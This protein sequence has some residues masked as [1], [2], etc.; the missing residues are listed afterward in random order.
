VLF[1]LRRGAGVVV[2]GFGRP[3][4]AEAAARLVAIGRRRGLVVLLGADPGL[5]A[6]VGAAG[7]HLPERALSKVRRLRQAHP[8]WILTGAVHSPRALARAKALPLD[9]IFYSTVFASR[10]PSA[11]TPMGPL[12]LA[13]AQRAARTRVHALGG[14]SEATLPRLKGTGIS[15][16]AAVE[17]FLGPPA[18]AR[19]RSAD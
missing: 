10:S 8:A 17:A 18:E 2:R 5:A 1:A 4:A 13:L 15:G 16:F 6:K 3:G 12:R 19:V 9:A 11:G 7:V 14:V